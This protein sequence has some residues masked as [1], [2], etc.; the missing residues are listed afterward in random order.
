MPEENL[1]TITPTPPPS[2]KLEVG[3]SGKLSFTVTSLAAPDQSKEVILQALL[4]TPQGKKEVDWLVP[5]PSRTLTMIGG[6]TETITITVKPTA[7]SPPG[8]NTIE[9]AIADKDN[10]N[11]TY[12]YSSPMTCEV[13]AKPGVTPPPSSFP[14]WLIPVIIGG[15]LVLGGAA[16]AIWKFVLSGAPE[17]GET[18]EPG[19]EEPCSDNLVCSQDA[20]KCLLPVGASCSDSGLCDS[21]ECA[22]GLGVCAR[23][24]GDACDPATAAT[25]PCAKDSHCDEATKTCVK[26]VCKPGEQQCTSDGKS[27]STCQD[28][29][30]FKTELCPPDASACRDGKCQCSPDRGKTCNCSGTIQCDGSCSAKPCE[31]TCNEGKCCSAKAGLPCGECKGVT[32]CD[33]SCSIPTPAGLGKTC[34]Q[35]G[36]V[37]KCDGTCSIPGPLNVGKPCGD[38]GGTV[39]CD[40]RCSST[41]PR[42]PA[43]FAPFPPDQCLATRPTALTVRTVTVP[44]RCPLDDEQIIKLPCGT[45]RVQAA[46]ASRLV[47]AGT[48][49]CEV[50]F[51]TTT[52]TT[53]DVRVRLVQPHVPTTGLPGSSAFCRASKCEITV[54]TFQRRGQCGK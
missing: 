18:C 19:G 42:C 45:G 51:A 38:C 29:G 47:T 3:Q 43:G 34:G 35:C 9:L 52:A 21:G 39:K 25:V 54:T 17:L 46:V 30:T 44:Q 50:K 24:L 5:G 28:N 26:D 48:G 8:V 32:K 14:K 20:K 37:L 7:S 40:G 36:G 53:C 16:F 2:L 10:P 49:R 41:T 15:V 1:F 23:R 13:V 22:T 6:K 11:D 12:V 27:L 33:G 31:S 4:V